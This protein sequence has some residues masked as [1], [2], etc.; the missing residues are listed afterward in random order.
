MRIIDQIRK[1]VGELSIPFAEVRE[2]FV[3]KFYLSNEEL[4]DLIEKNNFKSLEYIYFNKKNFHQILYDSDKLI[5]MKEENLKSFGSLFYF[6]LLI[7]DDP[8]TVNYTFSQK[9]IVDF[10]EKYKEMKNGPKKI[11][12]FKILFDFIE[13]Y[14]GINEDDTDKE[15]LEKISLALENNKL[16]KEYKDD[17][18]EKSLD[19]L[20][21]ELIIKLIPNVFPRPG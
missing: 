15:N 19:T 2:I 8:N 17:I 7:K 14:P 1:F 3:S 12:Y 11:I 10:S 5:Q 18:T 4:E 16:F 6:D 13:T 21:M 20:V 9:I